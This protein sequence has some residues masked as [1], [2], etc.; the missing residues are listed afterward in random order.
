MLKRAPSSTTTMGKPASDYCTTREK[1]DRLH[2]QSSQLGYP[3]LPYHA[4]MENADRRANQHRFR[5]EDGLIMVA[6]DRFPGMGIKQVQPAH[7]ILHYD[8]PRDIES[9]YQQI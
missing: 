3:A 1:V 7:F 9:Y 4:G 5:Y 6:T 2:V 8:L